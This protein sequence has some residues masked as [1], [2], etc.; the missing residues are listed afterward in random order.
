MVW[1]FSPGGA[2][3][4]IDNEAWHI[5]QV[6]GRTDIVFNFSITSLIAL[7]KGLRSSSSDMSSI[8]SAMHMLICLIILIVIPMAIPMAILSIL[9][10]ILIRR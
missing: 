6:N 8:P 5:Q 4:R 3:C 7:K 2:A 10:I 1:S 9:M